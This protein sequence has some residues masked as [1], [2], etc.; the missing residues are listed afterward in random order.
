MAI[1]CLEV[2]EPLWDSLL[3]TNQSSEVSGAYLSLEEWKAE[4]TLEP[5]RGFEPRTSGLGI[6]RTNHYDNF[7]DVC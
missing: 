3:F 2:A 6:Q 7:E 5:P 4:L 1:N